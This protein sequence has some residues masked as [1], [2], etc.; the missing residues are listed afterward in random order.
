METAQRLA[1]ARRIMAFLR[2][3]GLAVSEADVPVESFLP[4]L[5]TTFELGVFPGLPGLVAAG[6]AA[7][8]AQA[9]SLGVAPYPHM[10][11]WLRT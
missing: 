3:I 11:A 7:A 10:L 9:A 2:D 8:P 4:G 1:L 6:L 5:R